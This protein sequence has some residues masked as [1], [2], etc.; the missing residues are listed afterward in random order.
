MRERKTW[1]FTQVK[2]IKSDDTRKLVKD[3]EIKERRRVYFE[4]LL[5]EKKEGKS[6]GKTNMKT[7]M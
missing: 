7:I 5:N 2:Y 1:D 3:D 6:S 4:K